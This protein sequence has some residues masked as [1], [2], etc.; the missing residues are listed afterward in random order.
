MIPLIH[1][2]RYKEATSHQ[3]PS[4]SPPSQPPQFLRHA[5]W[6][7]AAS[8]C[9]Q[10]LDLREQLYSHTRGLLQP[11]DLDCSGNG[12]VA[13][14]QSWILVARYE[15]L[16][17]MSYRALISTG[18]A[19]RMAQNMGLFRIDRPARQREQCRLPEARDETEVEERRR[20]FW[21]VFCLDRFLSIAKR[22]PVLIDE[23]SVRSRQCL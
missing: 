19:V 3:A 21:A 10:Y 8:L 6:A 16:N 12:Q 2:S 13:V 15:L 4:W 5:M 17:M 7:L 1:I 11:A 14:L 18:R 9:P 20:A 22:L 23:R